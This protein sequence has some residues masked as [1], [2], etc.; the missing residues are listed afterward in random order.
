MKPLANRADRRTE[1]FV[2]TNQIKPDQTRSNRNKLD[3]T[4]SNQIKSEKTRSNQNKLD[5]TR[6]NHL[7]SNQK[8]LVFQ[9]NFYDVSHVQACSDA[10]CAYKI[11]EP[12][13]KFTYIAPPQS[14]VD[15]DDTRSVTL[16]FDAITGEPSN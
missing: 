8:N 3:Q 1:R 7:R 9:S 11:G 5:Q 16:I 14:V 2:R 10:K 12:R 6:S 4:R 15:V 13:V